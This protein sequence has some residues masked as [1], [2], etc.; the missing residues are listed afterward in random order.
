MPQRIHTHEDGL[1]LTELC[2]VRVDDEPH[3]LNGAH[4]SYVLRRWVADGAEAVQYA[5]L[6]DLDAGS[7]QFQRGRRG[8]PD[9]TP[10]TLDGAVLAILIVRYE[11]FQAGPFACPGND[12]VLRHLHAAAEMIKARARERAARG[13]LGK[14]EK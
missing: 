12:A 13:V 5:P 6:D 1:G 9:S 11:C 10:G 4:H 14:N 7:I 8:E 2:V 3:P